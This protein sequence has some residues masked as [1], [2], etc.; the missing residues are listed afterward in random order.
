VLAAMPT[1][2]PGKYQGSHGGTLAP[3]LRDLGIT[4]NQSARWQAVALRGATGPLLPRSFVRA[5]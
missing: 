5:Q 4:K 3:T 2:G 1:Q